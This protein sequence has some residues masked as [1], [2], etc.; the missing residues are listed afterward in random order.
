MPSYIYPPTE[1]LNPMRIDRFI[2]LRVARPLRKIGRRPQARRLPI[3]MYHSVS[4]DAETGVGAYYR[5]TTNPLRFAEQMQW[6]ADAGLRGVSLAEGLA[7]RESGARDE[8]RPVAI[9]FD[10]GF[11]D[12]YTSAYPALAKHGFTATMYLP[13]A[14]IHQERRTFKTRE[15]MTWTEVTELH[16]AGIE[17]GSHTV[18]HPKLVDLSW[19][20]IEREV[21]ESKN[22]I[23]NRLHGEISAFAY[24]YAFPQS[25]RRFANRLAE[26][27][28]AAGYTNNVTTAIGHCTATSNQWE[29]PRLPVNAMDDRAL[30]QA[31]LAGD[32]EWVG[33]FQLLRK[34]LLN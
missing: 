20:E 25:N 17:F 3:L 31:K 12:F 16:R 22:E 30:F 4:E 34:K 23:E 7:W 19:A 6:L 33:A 10:D 2:T 32:Y 21:V 26:L 18:N 1:L 13:T 15:C 5:V 27:L 29:L 8:A 11:R 9:T 24:P 14:F 28:K